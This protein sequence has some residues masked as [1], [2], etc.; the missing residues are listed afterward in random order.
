MRYHS[1]LLLPAAGLL[2]GTARA[3]SPQVPFAPALQLT[4][5]SSLSGEPDYETVI[6]VKQVDSGEA[7]LTIAWNRGARREWQSVE[8]R[9]SSRER[10]LARSFYFY[11]ST[12]N[13]R[14]YRGTTQSLL[15]GAVLNQLKSAGRADVVLLVPSLSNLPFR[16]TLQ[17]AG[18]G[19]EPFPVL[20]NGKRVMLPGIR[21]RGQFKGDRLL[22]F[23]V[24]V[25]DNPEAPWVLEATSKQVE[26]DR[27]GRRLLVRIGTDARG[28]EVA[29]TLDERCTVS[30]HD[31]YFA[32]GSDALDSTSA[33]A[34]GAIART[35][36][37]HPDWRI[38]I[39]GH[40]DSIGADA[41][42]LDLSR[43]RA[44]RVRTT[45]VG[46]YGIAADRLKSDGRGEKQPLDD[47]GTIS[48]RARNRRVDLVRA[49]KP[50]S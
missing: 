17:R 29:S 25:W 21:A 36:E 10:R 28:Q 47:N 35:L 19:A 37:S 9:V 24:L 48:G 50:S 1:L 30:I 3:Q 31:I 11:S 38:T 8:R 2:P 12:S 7:R 23:D 41:A 20:L 46:E 43:R 44:E 33:P 15:S 40:T 27:G 6:T 13:P 18:T 34:L 14:E 45:L 49:C 4:W 5:A 32:T 16:G 22:D 42:N 26:E 39:V